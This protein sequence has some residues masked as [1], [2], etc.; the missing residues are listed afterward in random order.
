[1]QQK[2]PPFL[3]TMAAKLIN[4]FFSWLNK[5]GAACICINKRRFSGKNGN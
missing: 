4:S 1:M 5:N 3:A 2:A